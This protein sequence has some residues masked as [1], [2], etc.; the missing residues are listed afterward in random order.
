MLIVL[1]IVIGFFAL[2]FINRLACAEKYTH[3]CL[4]CFTGGLGSG[5][6][7]L[8]SHL[9]L[10]KYRSAVIKWRVKSYIGKFRG[11]TY[12]KPLLISNIPILISEGHYS[13]RLQK[14]HLLGLIRIP[15][16]SVVFFDEAGK[17]LSQW[18]YGNPNIKKDVADF[19]RHFRHYIDGYFILTDQAS[20]EFVCYIRRR[21]NVIYN[22][23]DFR[24]FWL[25]FPFYIVDV[26]VLHVSEEQLTNTSETKSNEQGIIFTHKDKRML[27]YFMGF[28]P[29]SRKSK[30]YDSRCFSEMY[31]ALKRDERY[32][33]THD[34]FK[35]DYIIDMTYTDKDKQRHKEEL[36]ESN[37]KD[38]K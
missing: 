19:M 1:L 10:K 13:V 26:N 37:K 17:V 33:K 4:I 27:P 7:Y 5:K 29:Y 18:E 16:H 3:N 31:P 25:V 6:T 32:N 22:L 11:K 20:S 30:I 23:D 8:G 9:A 24:R 2:I 15:E 21:V 34:G 28:L 12:E 14:E 35:A 36:I 38:S